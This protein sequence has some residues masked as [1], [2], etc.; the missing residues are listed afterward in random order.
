MQETR[1]SVTHSRET[2]QTLDELWRRGSLEHLLDSNQLGI[3]ALIF[4]SLV[5]QF[6][7]DDRMMFV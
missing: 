6:V 4:A 3:Y 2:W 5:L 1:G 7:F